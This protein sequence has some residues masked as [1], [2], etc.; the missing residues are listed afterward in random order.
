MP[1]ITGDKIVELIQLYGL[2]ILWAVVILIVGRIVAGVASKLIA[3]AMTK[4]KIE[5][6]LVKFAANISY[7]L[8]MVFVVLAALEKVGVPT[9]NFTAILAAASLAIGF[10]LKDSLS[11]FASGVMMIVFRP[12][13][14]G[15]FVEAG[16]VAGTV[17]EIQIF[18]T[19]LRT[20]DN[21]TMI[22]PNGQITGGAITNYSL[23]PTRRIDMVIGVGY[24]DDLKKT[25]A[26]LESI[27]AADERVL[28]DPVPT[29][30]VSEL[31]DSSVN[32]VV[33]PWVKTADY[34]DVLFHLQETI[35][36]RFD[37]EGV[38]IPFPQRDVHVINEANVEEIA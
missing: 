17:E 8:F 1:E 28:E 26:V 31:A 30:G 13:K 25:R 19:Q 3:G 23:K 21:K 7:A 14:V 6:T 15:D 22:V 5:E 36:L 10:A 4:S 35:K 29:I 37:E 16:G 9:T 27:L 12:F 11:N 33:R 32:F 24:G 34:W 2:P 20:G 38:S 18:T